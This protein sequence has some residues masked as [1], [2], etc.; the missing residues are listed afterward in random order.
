MDFCNIHAELVALLK[1]P[2]APGF[3]EVVEFHGKLGHAVAELVEA[4]V[5]R[6]ERVCH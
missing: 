3:Y 5:D 2:L 4:E 6:G 1:D